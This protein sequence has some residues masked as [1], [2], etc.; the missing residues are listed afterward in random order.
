MK[1]NLVLDNIM[2]ERNIIVGF[3][4]SV[5]SPFIE[6]WQWMPDKITRY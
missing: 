5:L 1:K 3:A 2:Q 6:G 4:A